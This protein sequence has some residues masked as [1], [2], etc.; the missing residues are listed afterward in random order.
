MRKN[1]EKI[2]KIIGKFSDQIIYYKT[3]NENENENETKRNER[4]E[5]KRN[6]QQL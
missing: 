6:K 5:T 4:N 1:W 2:E 3:K